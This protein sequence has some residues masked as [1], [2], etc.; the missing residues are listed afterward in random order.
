V[1]YVVVYAAFYNTNGIF[2]HFNDLWLHPFDFHKWISDSW[3][4]QLK[5]EAFIYP[6]A[7]GFFIVEFDL[8][9]DRDLILNYGPWF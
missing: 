2:Y 7:N 9:E 4:P 8:V 1:L 3:K 6:C 5:E